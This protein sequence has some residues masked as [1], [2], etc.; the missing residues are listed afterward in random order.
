MT[1]NDYVTVIEARAERLG[2][3]AR[4]ALWINRAISFFLG[5]TVLYFFI[6]IGRAAEHWDRWKWMVGK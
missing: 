2:R 4:A 6:V 3:R 1:H 5:A